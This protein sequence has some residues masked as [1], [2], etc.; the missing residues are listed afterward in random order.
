M[1]N[2]KSGPEFLIGNLHIVLH[3][4]RIVAHNQVQHYRCLVILLRNEAEDLTVL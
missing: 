2:K 3:K 4:T 1:H